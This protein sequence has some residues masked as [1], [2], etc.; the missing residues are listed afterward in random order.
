MVYISS[1]PVCRVAAPLMGFPVKMSQALSLSLSLSLSHSSLPPY[2]MK[3]PMHVNDAYCLL[4]QYAY[5]YMY[6]YLYFLFKYTAHV[7]WH[8]WESV[9]L[10]SDMLGGQC[11]VLVWCTFTTCG[12][13]PFT[14]T[15]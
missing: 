6:L 7:Q 10:D 5:M 12:R 2:K 13:A 14:I 1:S 15:E 3:C 4:K 11:P 8:Q 9:F